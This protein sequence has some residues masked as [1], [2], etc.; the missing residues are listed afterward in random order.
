MEAKNL[1]EGKK[2][3]LTI[4]H[5]QKIPFDGKVGL[6]EVLG[7]LPM[8]LGS[9]KVSLTILVTASGKKHRFKVDLFDGN[10][11]EREVEKAL[12]ILGVNPNELELDLI[13]LADELEQHR[14][15]IF[16]RESGIIDSTSKVQ[17]ELSPEAE[18]Q[19]VALL[20]GGDV[21]SKIDGLLGKTGIVGELENRLCAFV[22][23]SSYK[24]PSPLHALVQGS[25]GSGKTH[26]INT[27]SQCLP[28][29]DILD[30]TRSSA[31]AFYHFSEGDLSLKLLVVQDFDGLDKESELAIREL[32]SA[33][34]T[35]SSLP[36]TNKL[37]QTK[38]KVKRVNAHFASLMATTKA[39]VYFDNM[40][41]SICISIDESVEQTKNIIDYDTKMLMGK[42]SKTE[43]DK[44]KGQLRNII[45]TLKRF[46]VVNPFADKISLP[47]EAKMLRRLNTQFQSFIS[48]ITI[49]NQFN[50]K[51]DKEGRLIAT[52]SDIKQAIDIFF[53]SIILKVDELSGSTRQFYDGLKAGIEGGKIQK[54]FSPKDVRKVLNLERTRVFEQLKNLLE[55]EYVKVVRGS[56]NKGFEYEL[57]AWDFMGKGKRDK[58]RSELDS[59]VSKLKG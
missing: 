11:I 48:Q 23:A 57:T 45:R 47:V 34:Y 15:D 22:V 2:S 1:L 31:K 8:D 59:Q 9:L 49:L 43:Q 58:I 18:K 27:I 53:S 56:K 5:S 39:E 29:E 38:T 24:M 37:G 4:H 13:Q 7:S 55:L 6:I 35:T 3:S 54:I 52:P 14:N 12:N 28:S 20:T 30:I 36:S 46:E 26:L 19:A 40:S 33:K 25:S 44:A 21:L 42:V 32:Q 16:E 51:T 50:R 10:S 41:R 17:N